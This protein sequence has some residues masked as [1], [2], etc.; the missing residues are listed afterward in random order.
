VTNRILLV[1]QYFWPETFGI[2]ALVRTLGSL[3]RQA[4]V[5]TGKPNYP[6]GKIF[7]G[8]KAWGTQRETYGE[9][10]VL[11]VPIVSRGQNSSVRLAMNY[12]SFIVA[13]YLL[14]P[15]LL[16][17]R[18]FDAIFVYA[19]SPLLQAL[20]AVF[21]AWLK[22]APL[23]VWVQDLWPESLAA[24]GFVQNRLGLI[25]VEKLVRH[26][27]A[28]ADLILIQSE[29]FRT[30]VARLVEDAQKIRYYP[31]AVDAEAVSSIGISPELAALANNIGKHFSVVFTGNLGTAQS[32]ETIVDAA[33]RL[34]AQA[35]IRFYLIGSGS[36]LDWLKSE[37][38]RRGLDNIVLAGRFPPAAMPVLYAASSALLVTLSDEAIFAYT[39]PSKLQGYLAA[40]RPIIASLNGE[41][42]RVVIE[43]KAGVTCGA[44]D[45]EALA[46]AVL[47]LYGMAS[48][49]RAQLGKNAR[50]YAA[51][52]FALDR[53]AEELIK[54]LDGLA[55]A[56]REKRK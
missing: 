1:S 7:P 27:Y 52:H 45:S 31:N 24:T 23:V 25:C 22:G 19:P 38:V 9:T 47:K 51:E 34:R 41:G 8:Y 18:R 43:A 54:H 28:H 35:D 44:G 4:T 46:Q 6:D 39:I 32:V 48:E 17:S 2:N 56:K 33:E 42:A 53:L 15:F 20:P 10:E 55:L 30:P 14:A 12:L 16:R 50:L 21:L 36:R 37:I 11:R 29:G 49:E 40:G 13:G 3:G 5:L 26:I